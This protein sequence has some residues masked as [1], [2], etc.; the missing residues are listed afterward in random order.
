MKQYTGAIFD[1]D[2]VLFD[3]ERLYQQTWAE[4]ASERGVTLGSD[5]MAT[6]SGTNG[7]VMH[8][9]VRRFYHV[10][11]SA[12]VINDCMARMREKLTRDVPVKPGARE[13]L[14]FFREAGFRVAVASSS[15]RA[16]IENN[17][18]LTGLAPYFD[19]VVSGEDV[20]AGKPDPAIF[21]RAA[22]AIQCAPEQCFVFEDSKNGVRAGHAAGCA[23][24]MV[25]DLVAPSPDILPL[26]FRVF[27]DLLAALAE[28]RTYP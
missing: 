16:Q 26:C 14:A 3:T 8:Q 25:P 5:F 20:S 13:I 27:P 18:S 22:A 15:R 24:I 23:T 11:D 6:I 12:A 10:S 28:L 19:A 9:I 7:E 17:L 2:G 1:M 21:L 4:L